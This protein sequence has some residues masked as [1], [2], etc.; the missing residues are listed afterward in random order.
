MMTRILSTL[1]LLT[2]SAATLSADDKKVV[3]IHLCGTPV[4][5]PGVHQIAGTSTVA[6]LKKDCG[7]WNEF[8]SDTRIYVIRF[9]RQEGVTEGVRDE[10]KQEII[11]LDKVMKKG[12][13]FSFREGDIVYVPMKVFFGR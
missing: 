7:G 9:P 10:T 12:G 13:E 6:R 4:N 8:G 3:R 5:K 1:C 2:L 11:Q